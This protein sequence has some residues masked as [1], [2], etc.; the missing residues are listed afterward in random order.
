VHVLR[1]VAFDATPY[2]TGSPWWYRHRAFVFALLYAGGFFFG[3][4]LSEVFDLDASP[5]AVQLGRA[6][7]EDGYRWFLAAACALTIGCWALRVWGSAYLRPAVVWNPDALDDRLIVAGPF[8]YVR[9]P[10]YLG[11]VLLALAMALFA[12]PIGA[13]LVLIGNVVLL[14]GLIRVEQRL[15]RARY[16]AAFDD[17]ARAVPALLPRITPY[18]AQR[19]AGLEPSYRL[20]LRSEIFSAGFVIGTAAFAAYYW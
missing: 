8:R 6:V 7:G 13:A 9:N 1:T 2:V 3:A 19:S 11:N 17:Y 15:L 4:L 20:G 16:G 10:L 14:A 18:E 5:V 12:T